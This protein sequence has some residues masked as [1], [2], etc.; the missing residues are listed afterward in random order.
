MKQPPLL[1]D[2]FPDE[3][4]GHSTEL[5]AA[6]WVELRRRP[7]PAAYVQIEEELTERIRA[8][9]LRPGDRIPPERELA[10]QMHVS[11]MTVRQALGRLADRGL[12]VRE[13]GRGTFVS[14]PKLVQ[15][16]SRLSG[17]YDQMI[18]QGIVP[19]SR[20]LSGEQILASTALAQVLDLRIGEPLYKVVRLRLG[21]G[22][23]LALET[24]FFPARLVPGL[25]EQDLER[26]SI[27]RLME[28][29]DARP[30]RAVQSLEPVPARDQDAELLEI[31]VGSPVMLVER[32]S[33]DARD[34]AVEYA[35]DIYRGDRSR[36]V[37][38]LHLER[39]ESGGRLDNSVLVTGD[40]QDGNRAGPRWS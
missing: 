33:W 30:V 22:V 35:K 19:T 9:K 5:P 24:S 3:L 1:L 18:S 34:R 32:T 25:L 37:T 20:L 8:G 6:M 16:L 14:E 7:G 27:Y 40:T 10:E 23:P 2:E 31:L 28:R 11:R 21:G 17:F 29:Y 39:G 12:L 13:Q 26:N 38:E 15:S 36:F 4:D